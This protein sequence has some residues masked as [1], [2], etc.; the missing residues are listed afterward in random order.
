[1]NNF[2]KLQSMPMDELAE[3]LSK[4]L[5]FDEAPHTI[6]FSKNCCDKCEPVEGHW[7]GTFGTHKCEFAYCELEHKCKFF[8]EMDEV[9]DDLTIVKMWLESEE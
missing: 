2:E 5:A 4:H 3:W 6:W 7:E 1:M 8:P 9:P